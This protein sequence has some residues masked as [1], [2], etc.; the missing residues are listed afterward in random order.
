MDAVKAKYFRIQ[1]WNN[2]S[3]NALMF[4]DAIVGTTH[5]IDLQRTTK[6]NINAWL[7]KMPVLNRTISANEEGVAD[8]V[9]SRR[10]INGGGGTEGGKQNFKNIKKSEKHDKDFMDGGGAIITEVRVPGNVTGMLISNV[11]NIKVRVLIIT[12]ENENMFQDL[13]YVEWE[14]VS[15]KFFFK[16]ANSQK[17]IQEKLLILF[18]HNCVEIRE[19][20]TSFFIMRCDVT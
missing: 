1:F 16:L 17:K 18:A 10:S 7:F 19:S 9:R 3:K 5:P 11:Q 20:D 4:P 6:A 15:F 2:N 12:E 8:E 13:R 14:S